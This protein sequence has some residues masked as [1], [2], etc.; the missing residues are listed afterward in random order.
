MIDKLICGTAKEPIMPV[1]EAADRVIEVRL[2]AD[3]P[4][5]SPWPPGCAIMLQKTIVLPDVSD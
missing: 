1:V 2:R 3:V 4:G 5:L